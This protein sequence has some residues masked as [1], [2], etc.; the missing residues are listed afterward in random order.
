ME[1]K[2][3]H[4]RKWTHPNHYIGEDWPEWFVFLG[5]HRDSDTLTRSNFECGLARLGGESET[6]QVIR[7]GHWA[8]GWVE[9]I[10]IHES[11]ADKLDA[12]E[13]MLGKLKDYPVLDDD[14]FSDLEWKEADEQW[15]RLSV[16]ERVDLCRE[17]GASI[18][19]ARRDYPP[20]D[21]SGYIFEALRG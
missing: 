3:K 21:D 11:A 15:K 13:I 17:A 4:L 19:A 6:V 1:N 7:E 14:H 2:F 9:W 5:Q 8:V 10:G 12:A 20:A 16:S 18:F